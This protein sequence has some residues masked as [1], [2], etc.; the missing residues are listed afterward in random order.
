MY[1]WKLKQNRKLPLINLI[2]RTELC[3]RNNRVEIEKILFGG[4]KTYIYTYI[5]INPTVDLEN[6]LKLFPEKLDGTA[7]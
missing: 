1:I 5:N 7:C 6:I 4:I 3:E 2:A